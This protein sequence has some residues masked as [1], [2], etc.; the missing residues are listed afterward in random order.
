[1]RYAGGGIVRHLGLQN[2]KGAVPALAELI[3][4]CWDADATEVHVS[5]PFDKPIVTEDIISLKDDG[6]GMNWEDCNDKYLVIG[7]NRRTAEKTEKTAKGRT[8]M[9]HK[10][11]GKLAGFGIAKTVEVRTVRNKKLTHFVMEFSE[12]DKLNQGETYRPRMIADEE[13]ATAENGTEITLRDLSLQRA[14]PEDQFL[15]SMMCKFSI[16]SSK[17]RVYVNERLLTREDIPTDMRFPEE[18]GDDVIAMQDGW[19]V[20]RIPPDITWWIG[21]T[22]K[23][24]KLE[25]VKGVSVLA[26]GKCCQDPWDF[27]LAGGTYGQHGLQYLTGEINADFLDEGLEKEDD[28]ILTNRSG[29]QWEDPRARP[30][31][32]WARKKIKTLLTV[33]VD[34]RSERTVD[35]VKKEKPELV[36]MIEQFQPRERKEL[37][38]A[39]KKLA[40]VPTIESDKL[41]SIFEYVIDGYKDKTFADMLTEIKDMPPEDQI[42]TLEV[43]K[44]F[45]VSEAVRVHRIVSAHVRVIRAFRQMIE[46][47]VPEK[48]DMHE[49]IKKYPWLLGLK[50]Q[51]MDY[52]RSLQKV[53]EKRFQ[54]KTKGTGG[55]KR[56]DFVCMRGGTDILV[57]ELKKPGE[58]AG[59]KELQQI[60]NYVYYLRKWIVKS[61]TEKLFGKTIG[62]EDV[63]GYLIV[64]DFTDEPAVE[65]L[66]RLLKNDRIFPFRWSELLQ[67]TEDDYGEFLKIIK[68]R[69]PRD[70]PRIVELE[71]KGIV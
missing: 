69:A 62:K 54:I 45:D 2:Y 23:P 66:I 10:G 61:A 11:L 56:P 64:G 4:N 9:A 21:F 5:I 26:R 53:L 44:E 8:L 18:V 70:D 16:L 22:E 30:L 3:S 1:M 68:S 34:R 60:S 25:G 40:E 20:T 55:R 46:A 36:Q 59:Q 43:L 48:P 31:Y 38:S 13:E 57:I 7:R 41:A 39:M 51:P 50:Y 65:D 27:D 37:N 32:E 15:R 35:A 71:K 33:W 19:G 12:I 63:V 29:V 58:K 14:I 28:L 67:K 6:C 42:K 17:F 52:E 24:I 47:G 49:Q